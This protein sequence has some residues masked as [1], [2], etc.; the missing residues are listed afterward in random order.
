MRLIHTAN[1]LLDRSYAGIPLPSTVANTCRARR[2]EVLENI[3]QRA[4]SWPA[5]AVLI[6]GNLFEHDRVTPETLTFLRQTLAGAGVPV[7]IAPGPRDPFAHD[8]PYARM[9]WPDNAVVFDAPSWRSVTL[10]DASLTVHGFAAVSMATPPALPPLAPSADGR[11]HIALAYGWSAPGDEALPPHPLGGA[12]GYAALGKTAQARVI[13]SF[14]VHAAASPEPTG[15]EDEGAGAYLEIEWTDDEVIVTPVECGRTSFLRW[16]I[17]TATTPAWADLEQALLARTEADAET[18]LEVVLTGP[19]PVAW[20]EGLSEA[21]ET[22]RERVLHLRWLDD[23]EPAE[24]WEAR[25]AEDSVAGDFFREINQALADAEG[26][27]AAQLRRARAHGWGAI[28]G[29]PL[30]PRLPVANPPGDEDPSGDDE[31]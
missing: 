3:I 4:A 13:P 14:P 16:A 26:P 1:I 11:R 21:R 17:D 12:V 22:L 9:P 25:A 8:S 27:Q 10:D 24:D 31:A 19:M 15:F 2:R 29:T 20:Q 18:V 23:T 30:P 7:L 6:A 5:D 28:E